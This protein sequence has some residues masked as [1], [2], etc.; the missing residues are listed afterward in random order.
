[1]PEQILIENLTVDGN[2]LHVC[3]K[4]GAEVVAP[5]SE[6]LRNATPRERD[7]WVLVAGGVGVSWPE[8][9]EDLSA[10]GLWYDNRPENPPLTRPCR[11]CNKMTRWDGERCEGCG[12]ER[13][14]DPDDTEMGRELGAMERRS[15]EMALA[16]SKMD[17]LLDALADAALAGDPELDAAIDAD[18]RRMRQDE[19]E[20]EDG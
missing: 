20:D 8:L 9:D 15:Y 14:N 16:R 3:F 17:K 1:M 19:D 13:W 10:A 6:R 18:M 12:K 7:R 4:H 5:L 11:F 2:G